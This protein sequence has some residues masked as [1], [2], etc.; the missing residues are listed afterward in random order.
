[1][2]RASFLSILTLSFAEVQKDERLQRTPANGGRSAAATTENI[3]TSP[4]PPSPRGG[5]GKGLFTGTLHHGIEPRAVGQDM[6]R[7]DFETRPG[8][9]A[10]LGLLTEVVDSMELNHN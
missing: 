7:Q 1:M 10:P 8:T 2:H 5:K 3:V 9:A 6:M 4:R